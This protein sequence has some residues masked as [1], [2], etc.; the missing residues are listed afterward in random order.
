MKQWAKRAALLAALAL[1]GVIFA[2]S[3]AFAAQAQT[4]SK[5]E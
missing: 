2:A 5:G 3:S 1:V 4:D